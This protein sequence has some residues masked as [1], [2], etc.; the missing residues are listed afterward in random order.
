MLILIQQIMIKYKAIYNINILIFTLLLIM[1]CLSGCEKMIEVDTPAN[2]LVSESVYQDS[3][4]AQA[5]VNG[6]YSIMYNGSGQVSETVFGTYVTTYPARTADELYIPTSID[7]EYFYNSILPGSGTVSAVWN[8]CY[9]IIYH[10]NSIIAG[11]ESSSLSPTLKKQLIGEAKFIRAFCHFTLVNLFGEV[12]LVTT[13]DV[14]ITRSLPRASVPAIYA[15]MIAD[16]K[17]AQA[18][19]ASDYSWSAGLR[20]RANKWAATALLARVYLYNSNWAQAEEESTKVIAQSLYSMPVKLSDVFL[21][22]SPE[23]IWQ[24]NTNQYG[25]TFLGKLLIPVTAASNPAYAI[26]PNLMAA[27]EKDAARKDYD[28][29]RDTVWIKLAPGGMPYASKYVSNVSAANTEFDMVLRLAEQYLI[30]AEARVQQDKLAGAITDINVIRGRA[31]LRGTPALT[32]GAL[33]LAVE[34]ERQVELFLEYGHR[35]FD[36]K[37]TGRADAVLS[38]EK[39]LTWKSTAARYPIPSSQIIFNSNLTQ[40]S[41]Y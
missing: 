13:T 23:A 10:A 4:T 15:Q 1:A 40:N 18:G 11:M 17:D 34:H 32:K 29:D 37:R 3:L 30:R 8:N 39:P 24:F 14:A 36:L 38:A 31:G 41:G 22:A 20:T 19:L 2:Q 5:A 28:D 6:M 7:D 26:S 21:K 35:L 16:L 27:F 9:Q 12:P 25:Y 33:L